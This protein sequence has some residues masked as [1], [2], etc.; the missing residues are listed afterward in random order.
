M[1]QKKKNSM[2]IKTKYNELNDSGSGFCY[3]FLLFIHLP[4]PNHLANLAKL[5]TLWLKPCGRFSETG[6]CIMPTV[7]SLPRLSLFPMGLGMI[8]L[9]SL[10]GITGNT[11]ED[12]LLFILRKL[13]CS[14]AFWWREF[15]RGSTLCKFYF[16]NV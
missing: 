10:D 7:T 5:H 14:T 4:I 15:R 6:I 11:W 8:Q 13:S 2:E 9:H 1:S 16:R 3:C 12:N